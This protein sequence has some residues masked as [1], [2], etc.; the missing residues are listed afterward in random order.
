MST[1]FVTLYESVGASREDLWPMAYPA[2][3]RWNVPPLPTCERVQWDGPSLGY[4]TS[5]ESIGWKPSDRLPVETENWDGVEVGF[6]FIRGYVCLNLVRHPP[7]SFIFVAGGGGLYTLLE[8][9][10]E[11]SQSFQEIAVSIANE[12]GSRF[13]Q[14]L[15]ADSPVVPL[16]EEQVK[17]TWKGAR[18]PILLGVRSDVLPSFGQPGWTQYRERQI[19]QYHL[20]LATEYGLAIEG[21]EREEY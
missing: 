17:E 10:L 5:S 16:S 19:G 18:A 21:V 14:I 7:G 4:G 15:L 20:F 6:D 12:A 9:E 1:D 13:F 8:Y 2:F 3:S 11:Y